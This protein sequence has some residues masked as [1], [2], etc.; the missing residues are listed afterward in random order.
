MPSLLVAVA[1]VES[2]HGLICIAEERESYHS[3]PTVKS[4]QCLPGE[5]LT[6]PAEELDEHKAGEGGPAE[7][8]EKGKE[9]ERLLILTQG[10]VGQA[11]LCCLSTLSKHIYGIQDT[12]QGTCHPSHQEKQE[13][14]QGL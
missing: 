6:R 7:P 13:E 1:H 12:L 5:W 4:L 8:L 2:L 9:A 14:N 3:K 11:P 10:A